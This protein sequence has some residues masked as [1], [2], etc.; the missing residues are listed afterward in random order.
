MKSQLQNSPQS[1]LSTEG[2]KG[3]AIFPGA[4]GDFICFLPALERMTRWGTVDLLARSEYAALLSPQVRMRPLECREIAALFVAGAGR[5]QRLQDFFGP[6]TFVYSWMG[7]HQPD[8]VSNLQAL[9]Q[10]DLGI[11]P[12][13]P[14]QLGIHMADYYLSCLEEAYL[15][16]PLPIIPIRSDAIAWGD[17]FWQGYGLEGR[18]VLALAPGSGAR[19][20]NW[21]ADFF[22]SAAERWEE[23]LGHKALVILGPVEEERAEVGNPWAHGLVVRGLDLAQLAALL[24]RSDLYLG[25]DSGVTHL[26]AALGVKTIALFGPTDARQWAPRGKRVTVVTRSVACSPCDPPVMKSCPH[27][28]CLAT[29]SP[30]D[31]MRLALMP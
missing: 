6:Y 24:A 12:F 23:E 30:E 5:D 16:G 7:N 11:F 17:C 29:I 19:G 13:H 10:G 21:P 20:K 22:Q 28:R 2:R 26:A 3:L 4:L 14:S 31:V 9:C 8:F 15:R 1:P 27:R 18:K 25:N